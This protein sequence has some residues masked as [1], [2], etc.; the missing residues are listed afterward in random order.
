[1]SDSNNFNPIT[2]AQAEMRNI[3]R[4]A[5]LEYLRLVK[6]ASRTEIAS[7]LKISLPSIARIIE[8]LIES[9]L[10]RSTGQ[11]ERSRGRGRD[12][13][14]LN[15]EENLV[16]GSIWAAAISAAP[17]SIWGE[18]FCTDSGIRLIGAVGKKIIKYWLAFFKLSSLK[19]MSRFHG[20]WG[21]PSGFPGSWT[22]GLGL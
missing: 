21:S 9:G 12:L 14:E 15:V 18:K 22:A 20:F 11:R 3:N 2:I 17:W 8:Q 1:M 4:S 7:Q 10:V 19:Q 16:I 13:L 6:I 5:V